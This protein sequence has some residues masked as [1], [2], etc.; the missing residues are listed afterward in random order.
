[1]RRDGGRGFAW[2][3]TAIV[4]LGAVVRVAYALSQQQHL[5]LVGDSFVYSEGANALA[6][7]RGWIDPFSFKPWPTA[8][9]PPLY[10]AWLWIASYASN[11]HHAT[12]L[13]HTLWSCIPGSASVLLCGLAGKEIGGRRLGLVAATLAAL[14]PGMWINDGLVLSET[15]AIFAVAGVLL[16]AYRY[17]NQPSPSRAI[18]LGAWCGIA[19]LSRSELVLTFVLVLAPLVLLTRNRRWA[20]RFGWL[21]MAGAVGLA[22]ISPW[23]IFNSGRFHQRVLLS[24]GFGRTMAAA[25]CDATYSGPRL[26]FKS[27]ECLGA[28]T[29]RLY[30]PTMDESDLDQV[31]RKAATDYVKDHLRD[32]HAWSPRVGADC[33]SCTNRDRRSRSTATTRSAAGWP[34]S[35]SSGA[36]TRCSCS[37]SSGP[38]VL[39][40]RRVPIYPLLAIFVIAVFAVTITFAQWRYRGPAEPALV[41][42]AAVA[43]DAGLRRWWPGDR[44]TAEPEVATSASPASAGVT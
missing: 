30:K 19:A 8:S 4:V 39:R 38:C 17:W 28:T 42:L 43:I 21:A 23:L 13:T 41:L 37:R 15:M 1:M 22:V 10:I 7:G 35:C 3:L 11:N 18:W 26:G 9:H 31:T 32:V 40:S 29:D 12:Q 24:S 25:N 16:F 44:G 27:Y 6:A 20:L 14:Y 36:S 2:S 5:P 34:P 33:C